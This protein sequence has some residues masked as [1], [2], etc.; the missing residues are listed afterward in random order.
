MSSAQLLPAVVLAIGADAKALAAETASRYP[1]TIVGVDAETGPV[2]DAALTAAADQV[3]AALVEQRTAVPAGAGLPAVVVVADTALAAAVATI[4]SALRTDTTSQRPR[5]WPT[6]VAGSVEGLG[7]F[8]EQLDELGSGSCDLVLMMNSDAPVADKADALAA[9]LHVKMPAP[10][11]VLG[12]LPDVNGKI[13]R[14]V[15][16][17][18][19]TTPAAGAPSAGQTPSVG[20][21][22]AAGQEPTGEAPGS[23]TGV[24]E[25]LDVSA[26]CSTVRNQLAGAAQQVAVTTNAVS[27]AEALS[28][29]ASALDAPALIRAENHLADAIRQ[30]ATTLPA[31]L[32][33]MIPEFT[34]TAVKESAGRSATTQEAA[35]AD[36][37]GA[38]ETSADG[39]GDR[40]AGG[41]TSDA[42]AADRTEA[43]GQLV[44]M[45]SKGGLSKMFAKSRM[46][47]VAQSISAAATRDVQ[48]A[49]AS[50]LEQAQAQ[51]DESVNQFVESMRQERETELAKQREAVVIA[52]T[53]DWRDAL[54]Q[55]RQQVKLWSAVDTSGVRRSWGGSAPAPR[56]YIVGSASALKLLP[57]EDEALHIVDLTDVG[58]STSTT[59]TGST[60][61]DGEG[62]GAEGEA[63]LEDRRAT[64]LLAQYGLP[65]SAF[66]G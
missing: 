6:F 24:A 2:A 55:C 66:V 34:A 30:V 23:G 11:S 63:V 15:A 18:A 28:T 42:A 29:A 37:G 53:Q 38:V 65:L 61:A 10:P 27:S 56:H 9:W 25:D 8:D 49:V 50:A 58:K 62:S 31:T 46:A 48:V 36:A 57:D 60:S 43:V 54:E 41:L 26:I 12:E 4:V 52:S 35:S 51:V 39:V 14:Y 32:T 44:L 64:V 19:A 45:A 20:R 5:V 47:A 21:S 59:Q 16:I 7:A 13:C 3:K 40:S 17:G 1:A 33:G 22:S